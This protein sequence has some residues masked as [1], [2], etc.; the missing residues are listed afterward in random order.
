MPISNWN[1]RRAGFMA[2]QLRDADFKVEL[3]HDAGFTAKHL[4]DADSILEQLRDVR[5]RA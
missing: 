5:C 2:K 4:R 3:L 1:S